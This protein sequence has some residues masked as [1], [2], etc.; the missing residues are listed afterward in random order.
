MSEK[1]EAGGEQARE[2]WPVWPAAAAGALHGMD[3][4]AAGMAHRS[5]PSACR[6]LLAARAKARLVARPGRIIAVHVALVGVHIPS[7]FVAKRRM[8]IGREKAELTIHIDIEGV[9][10]RHVGRVDRISQ[11]VAG[12]LQLHDGK[13]DVLARFGAMPIRA[14][15]LLDGSTGRLPP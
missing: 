5:A 11:S 1:L 8:L 15:S 4:G 3:D 6:D 12:L 13:F 2:A 7:T 10:P 14:R 9:R